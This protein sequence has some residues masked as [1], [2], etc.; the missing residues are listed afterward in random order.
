LSGVTGLAAGDSHACAIVAGGA[1]Y[2]WGGNY[3][4]QLGNGAIKPSSTPVTVKDLSAI[5]AVSGGHSHS[6]ALSS[7]DRVLCWGRNDS[8]QLGNGTSTPS[9]VPVAVNAT[10]G[11][12]VAP[13]VK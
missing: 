2:C 5:V 10:F 8:G 7:D 4:G 3:N 11:A 1:V 9:R 13:V 6:C 12:G